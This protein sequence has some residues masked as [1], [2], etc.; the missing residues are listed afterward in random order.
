M[1]DELTASGAYSYPI[2]ADAP[3]RRAQ[4]TL[5]IVA[6]TG[7]TEELIERLVRRFY[8]RVREDTELGPIFAA[9]VDDWE[10]HIAKLCAFWSSIALMT[11]RYH[12]QPMR[13]HFGLP[14]G[15]EHFD[16]WLGLFKATTA[17]VC[18]GAAAEHL[19]GRARRIA[20]SIEMGVGAQRGEILSPRHFSMP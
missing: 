5:D 12:G 18:P 6:R 4:V 10:A 15:P 13:V 7:I 8:D 9:R 2:R 1:T 14:V 3:E 20:N 16:R 17:E 11:G 19:M